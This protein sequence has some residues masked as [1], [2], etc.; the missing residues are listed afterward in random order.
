MFGFFLKFDL[1]VSASTINNGYSDYWNE[2]FRVPNTKHVGHSYKTGVWWDGVVRNNTWTYVDIQLLNDFEVEFVNLLTVPFQKFSYTNK[3]ILTYAYLQE[4][5]QITMSGV[6]TYIELSDGYQYDANLFSIYNENK[7]YKG[8]EIT[9]DIDYD[10]HGNLIDDGEYVGAKEGYEY[11]L[12]LYK[13]SLEVF[14]NRVYRYEIGSW[15]NK[16]IRQEI[17]NE[18]EEMLVGYI[19]IPVRIDEEYKSSEYFFLKSGIEKRW[20]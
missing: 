5:T 2:G 16:N 13:L 19:V 8:F 14:Y 11:S 3:V 20:F 17:S 7:S 6:Y 12:G 18:C 4:F 1:N 9:R 15:W 10:L